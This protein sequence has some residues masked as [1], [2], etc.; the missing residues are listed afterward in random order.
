[1]IFPFL[2]DEELRRLPAQPLPQSWL[3][4]LRDNV[5]LYRTLSEAEQEKL[6]GLVQVF[7]VKKFWEGCGG[8]QI[9][10][11][12]QVTIAGQACLLLLGFDD[13]CFEGLQTILVYPGG[14]L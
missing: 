7:I 9:T 14:Y 4:F 6:R 13:Y 10:E 5:L 3:A 12:I 1:M 11:E 2:K 8:L